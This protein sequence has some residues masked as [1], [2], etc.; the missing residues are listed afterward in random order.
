MLYDLTHMELK[1]LP[2]PNKLMEKEVRIAVITGEGCGRGHW[3]KV[4]KRSKFPV[5]G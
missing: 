2:P 4:G 1:T 3:R 5:I